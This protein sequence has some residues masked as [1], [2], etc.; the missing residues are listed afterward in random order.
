MKN[1]IHLQDPMKDAWTEPKPLISF[2]CQQKPFLIVVNDSL[3]F[4]LSQSSFYTQQCSK[5]VLHALKG[6]R[7]RVQ[8]DFSFFG[9]CFVLNYCFNS[10]MVSYVA[11]TGF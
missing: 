6:F 5:N 9:V 3:N 7:F 2:Y 10:E 8:T 4:K 11:S 1:S